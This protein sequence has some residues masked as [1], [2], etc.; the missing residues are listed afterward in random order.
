MLPGGN[1]TDFA[2]GTGDFVAHTDT[3]SPA[4]PGSP[5]YY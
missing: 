5:P 3:K 2:V 1:F 4:S